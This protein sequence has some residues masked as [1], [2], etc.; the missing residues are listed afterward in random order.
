[1]IRLYRLLLRLLP[2]DL[3]TRFGE[4]MERDVRARLADPSVGRGRQALRFAAAALD[5]VRTTVGLRARALGQHAS[6]LDAA[7]VTLRHALRSLLRRP[8]LA[9]GSVGTLG[10]ALALTLVAFTVLDGALLRPLPYPAADRLALVNGAASN[11]DQVAAWPAR[12]PGVEKAA[13]WSLDQTVVA[14]P[15]GAREAGVLAVDR[16]FADLVALPVEE[17]RSFADDEWRGGAPVVMVTRRLWRSVYGEAPLQAQSLELDGVDRQVVGIVPDDFTF[18]RY[19]GR[20][21]IRPLTG[22][23]A[24]GPVPALVRL[25]PG[26][27]LE[28]ARA[29][30]EAS[31]PQGRRVTVH[32]L[33]DTLREELRGPLWVLLAAGGLVLMIAAANVGSL[34]LAR[35]VERQPELAVRQ[36]LGAGRGRI[37]GQIVAEGALLAVAGGALGL[38]LAGPVRRL[39]LQ[40]TPGFIP[41]VLN[42]DPGLRAPLATLGGVL[43][44][45]TLTGLLPALVQARRGEARLRP[46]LDHD[47]RRAGRWMNGLVVAEAAF[48]TGLVVGAV[49]LLRT[50]VAVRPTH[51]GFAVRDRVAVEVSLPARLYSD[52][53]RVRDFGRRLLAAAAALP[54][55]PSSAL[56]DFLP[57]SGVSAYVPVAT[58]EAAPDARPRMAHHRAASPG[59]LALMEMPLVRGRGLETGDVAGAPTV[60][61]VNESAAR[62]LWPDGSEPVGRTLELE[63]DGAPRTFSVVGVVADARFFG[64]GNR[65]Q[66]EVFTSFS[67]TP[68]RTVNLVLLRGSAPLP[69]EADLRAAIRSVDPRVPVTAVESLSAVAAHT[70]VVP[71]FQLTLLGVLA[72]AGLLLS[73]LGTF[74]VL[75]YRVRRLRRE[76]G[77]RKALG[78]PPGRLV[79]SLMGRS[80]AVGLAGAVAGGLATWIAGGWLGSRL[81]LYGVEPRDAG[82]YLAA[83][84]VMITILALGSLAPCLHAWRMDAAVNL[85]DERA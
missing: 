31:A 52:P 45:T 76:I 64:P 50:F 20:D 48:A 9:V 39:L 60:A 25:A 11:A 57:L 7:R 4:E 66:P 36:A 30:L 83:A 73:A 21:V 5:V 23:L 58:A 38:A 8:L 35:D 65:A 29:A 15:D 1:M 28:P 18:F 46:G 12:L 84:A 47:G 41:S 70:T 16:A 51:P 74:S 72:G 33:A 6:A 61:V 85:T 81:F 43:L 77:I 69:S 82:P 27:A 3:R 79:S 24:A 56:V 34:A 54:G 49:L 67:Q 13:A 78:C 26:A 14:A 63:I 22:E 80:V 10:L 75:A 19:Q 53:D 42:A 2:G 40:A 62:A 17:G 32:L 55:Q 68:D 71:R 37:T 59:Y 44:A